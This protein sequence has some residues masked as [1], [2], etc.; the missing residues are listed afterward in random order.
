MIVT[1]GVHMI[2]T[3]SLNELHE[4]AEKLGFKKVGYIKLPV[5][6]IMI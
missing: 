4:F 3:S 1:D 2:A 6:H 5:D